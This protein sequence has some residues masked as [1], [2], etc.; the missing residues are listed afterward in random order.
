LSSFISVGPHHFLEKI[1]RIEDQDEHSDSLDEK[2]VPKISYTISTFSL[3]E[4]KKPVTHR[5]PKSRLVDLSSDLEWVDVKAHLKIAIC[6]LLFP[7]QAVVED[8]RYEMTWSI[9]RIVTNPLSLHTIADHQQ[10]VK[11]ALKVKEPGV[12]ILVDELP[13]ITLVKIVIFSI[14]NF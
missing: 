1:L 3:E 7:H 11:K 5:K 10:L 4:L 6:D 9:P 13:K 2:E 12:K 14:F 8:D